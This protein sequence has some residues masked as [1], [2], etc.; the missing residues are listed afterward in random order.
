MGEAYSSL[1]KSD[2]AMYCLRKSAQSNKAE[3]KYG[4]FAK[5]AELARKRG[6]FEKALNWNDS[7]HI[8]F[9]QMEAA[10][11][12]AM[13]I[14]NLKDFVHGEELEYYRNV[15]LK[16]QAKVWIFFVI[17]LLITLCISYDYV[18]TRRKAKLY[19]REMERVK[20]SFKEKNN[21]IA[22]LNNLLT[23]CE[24]DKAEVALLKHQIENIKS[25]TTAEFNTILPGLSS[26]RIIQSWLQKHEKLKDSEEN[27]S[28]KQWK[29]IEFELDCVTN[30]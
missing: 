18:C 28:P 23:E 12:P 2:S 5:L 22:R 6:M 30:R 27:I 11:K 21:E 24:G 7:S 16:K 19:V 14:S 9:Y 1:G 29:E 13:I 20:L 8:Y 25:E 26:Y 10:R 4:S 17:V 15:S 3:I